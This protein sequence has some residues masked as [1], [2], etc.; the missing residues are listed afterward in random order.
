MKIAIIGTGALGCLFGAKL[1]SNNDVI[2]ITHRQ[3]DAE[4]INHNGLYVKENEIEHHYHKNLTAYCSA[5][6]PQTVDLVILLVKTNQ[7]Q[8]ALQQNH[9]IIRND[10]LLITLQNGFG[11]YE[12][13]SEYIKDNRLF[14]G[15]TNHNSVL[16]ECGKVFHS[17]EGTTT[18][19]GK[20]ISQENI[21]KVLTLFGNVGFHCTFSDNIGFFLWK[22]LFVNL[23]INAFTY[24]TCSPIGF[25]YQNSHA[26]QVVEKIISE[27]VLVAR[28]EGFN[29]DTTD[30]IEFI[31]EISSSHLKGYSSMFQ[32]RKKGIKTEI[33]SINGAVVKLA[34][35]HHL[36]VPCNE[37]IVELV[38]AIEDADTCNKDSE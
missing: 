3:Q 26:L 12:T 5:K 33:D 14:L 16:L 37:L 27:A 2:L 13:I 10:T 30:V 32:D 1:S 36:S 29:F 18:I 31:K 4:I 7:S 21:Q 8:E 23:A 22:K 11:N 24:I 28:A 19:G 38:H 17:G 34:R 25:I 35:K 15:T 20:N 6:C 9:P